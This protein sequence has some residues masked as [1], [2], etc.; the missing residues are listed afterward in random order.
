MIRAKQTTKKANGLKACIGLVW[1]GLPGASG[2]LSLSSETNQV[3]KGQ[4]NSSH[5]HF[6]KH[7]LLLYLYN[8]KT[9]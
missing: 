3:S 6:F 5:L 4:G 7:S 2:K 1:V 9:K 8:I